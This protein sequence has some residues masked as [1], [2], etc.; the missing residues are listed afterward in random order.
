ML[1][2]IPI[3][4][5]E[6]IL[7]GLSGVLGAVVG[8]FLNVCIYRI[9]ID[10]LHIGNP[11]GSFCPSC[12]SAVRWYD[13]IPVLAWLWLRGRCRDCSESISPRYPLVE[14]LTS[15]LFLLAAYRF[16]GDIL[17]ADLV[18]PGQIDTAQI[19]LLLGVWGW[20]CALIVVSGIDLDHKI[21]PDRISIPATAAVL[22]V[23]PWNPVVGAAGTVE[24]MT[25]IEAAGGG[26]SLVLSMLIGAVVLGGG[27]GRWVP[28][29]EGQ[30]RTL[31]ESYL[32]YL[33]GA[34]IGVVVASYLLGSGAEGSISIARIQSSL[35]GAATGAGVIYGVG[36]IG[37]IVFRKPAM[38]FGDVKWM[39]LLGATLGPLPA[40]FAFL[41]AC[42][43]GSI[44]GIWMRLRRGASYIPFGPFLSAGALSMLLGRPELQWIWQRYLALLQG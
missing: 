15:A 11:R 20:I 31:V 2:G 5:L 8:S 23:S 9:P 35:V 6:P 17:G 12:K 42:L 28:N 32:F 25:L 37:S 3:E 29:W 38:G 43:L 41:I 7:W 14:G 33:I 1:M 34:L 4:E 44:V 39:G 22:L 16:G 18:V 19:L 36:K 40:L 30:R 24:S 27:F 13:N 26:L 21:I 10:G